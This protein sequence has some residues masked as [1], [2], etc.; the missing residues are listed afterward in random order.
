M[1]QPNPV[2]PT[3]G[4]A[5]MRAAGAAGARAIGAQPVRAAGAAR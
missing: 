4:G 5:G 1:S 2:T 3:R